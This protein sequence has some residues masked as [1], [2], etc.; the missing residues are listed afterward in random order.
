MRTNSF[1]CSRGFTLVE[2]LVTIT[3]LAILATVAAPNLRELL[4]TNRVTAQNNEIVGLLNL[5]KSEAIRRSAP[6]PVVFS[7]QAGGWLGEVGTPDAPLL[8]AD[9]NPVVVSGCRSGVLR[10]AEYTGVNLSFGSA[11]AESFEFNN[12][13]YLEPFNAPPEARTLYLEHGGCKGARQRRIIEVLPTGQVNSCG[14]N[15]GG[16]TCN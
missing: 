2:L 14:A 3:V 15:C 10:C 6:V 12:R 13:G 4:K 9:G 16:V 7:S 5:A 8:D 1:Q 11:D